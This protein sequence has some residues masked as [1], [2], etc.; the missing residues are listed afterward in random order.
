MPTAAAE[1]ERGQGCSSSQDPQ[2]L[3]RYS[4][5]D[6]EA[7]RS[8]IHL[9][10]ARDGA[11]AGRSWL[12]AAVPGWDESRGGREAHE[13]QVQAFRGGPQCKSGSG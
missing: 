6:S 7:G 3:G 11:H 8:C 13:E 1:E 2:E 4:S 5:N 9:Q 10:R 12:A